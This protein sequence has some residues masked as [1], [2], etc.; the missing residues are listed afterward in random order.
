MDPATI[1]TI[2][3]ITTGVLS[4]V[5]KVYKEVVGKDKSVEKLKQL[6]SRL[7]TLNKTA[8]D[9]SKQVPEISSFPTEVFD[10][11]SSLVQT[12]EECKEFLNKYDRALSGGSG[13]IPKAQIAKF[14][15]VLDE[16]TVKSF[17][18]RIDRHY[19]ELDHWRL[20]ALDK[21]IR[22]L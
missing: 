6:K 11:A 9:I 16:N 3:E 21:G 22:A 14:I 5:G 20:R 13:L 18:E 7:E 12:L 17:H 10:G 1:Y 4:L 19:K 2:L 8:E 15:V